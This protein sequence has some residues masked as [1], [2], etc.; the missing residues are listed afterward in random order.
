MARKKNRYQVMEQYMSLAL[1]GDVLLFIGYLIVSANGII[2]A[3]AVLAIIALLL[4]LAV[5]GFLYLTQELLRP[6]SLW[7]STA[8]AAILLCTVFSLILNFP[9]P[10]YTMDDVPE[11]TQAAQQKIETTSAVTD[12]PVEK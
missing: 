7:M 9:R 8:A 6:R 5:L 11:F 1:L 3:K 2:W 12:S 4:S 10:K